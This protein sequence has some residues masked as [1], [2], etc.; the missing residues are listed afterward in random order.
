MATASWAMLTYLAICFSYDL[1]LQVHDKDENE[2][3]AKNVLGNAH[4][5]DVCKKSALSDVHH[6]HAFSCSI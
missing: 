1:F 5:V 2:D 6:D 3:D 4:L